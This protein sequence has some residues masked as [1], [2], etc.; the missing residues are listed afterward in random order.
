MRL[1][2]LA[3]LLLLLRLLGLSP[4][5]LLL[6]GL[7]PLLLLLLGLL[8]TP[9]LLLL[10]LALLRPRL[11]LLLGLVG[12]PRHV[13]TRLMLDGL[14]GCGVGRLCALLRLGVGIVLT[15]GLM[16]LHLKCPPLGVR[17]RHWGLLQAPF[18]VRNPRITGG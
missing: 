16:G 18:S 8:L 1:L 2:L 7:T 10:L 4:L 5:L 12:L 15:L 11:L 13:L 3:P 17:V 14:G 9:L 6:L